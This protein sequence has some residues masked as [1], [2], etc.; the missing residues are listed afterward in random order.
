MGVPHQNPDPPSPGPLSIS[1]ENIKGLTWDDYHPE[2]R[3]EK[4]T[5]PPQQHLKPSEPHWKHV[6]ER[7]QDLRARFI[8]HNPPLGNPRCSNLDRS[9]VLAVYQ[10]A[11]VRL[12]HVSEID[13]R[14][15]NLEVVS[16]VS[17]ILDLRIAEPNDPVFSTK[18]TFLSPL[19]PHYAHPRLEYYDREQNQRD[20]SYYRAGIVRLTE[21]RREGWP[22]NYPAKAVERERG[23]IAKKRRAS[24]VTLRQAAVEALLAYPMELIAWGEEVN[25]D[26]DRPWR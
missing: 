24:K 17:T 14:K 16:K 20:D 21:W 4:S 13:A 2:I 8:V 7:I 25:A 12:E 23:E 26:P 6:A 22:K 11:L 19:E 9:A 18:D 1:Y 10:E 5:Q 3:A 15:I